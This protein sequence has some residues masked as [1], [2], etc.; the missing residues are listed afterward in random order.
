VKYWEIDNETWHMGAEAYAAA[1]NR[2]GPAMR[3]ADPSIELAACGSGGYNQDWN[4]TIINR[5]GG[6]FDYISTHHYEGP[7]NYA[8]GP[9][10]D[11]A[12]YRELKA[13]IDAGPNPNIKVYCSEWN[14]QS[15]DWRTGLYCG[16]IL[17]VFERCGDFF[18]IGGP[19]LFLRHVSATAWDNA[20]VNF[21][22]RTW[23]PAP[24]YV[25]MKLWRDHYCP[26]RI[27]LEGETG[28]LNVVATRSEDGGTICIKAVNPTED[29]M[30]VKA[31]VAGGTIADASMQLVAPGRLDARNTLD[32]RGTVRPEEAKVA[33]KGS[34]V[35]FEM[36]AYSAGAVTIATH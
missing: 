17:N 33:V 27:D 21:D 12:F 24:N 22:H 10:R 20:F 14:A 8:T 29:P 13:I 2:F 3:K 18:E 26:Q 19:A 15:T 32:S 28:G 30:S 4:R 5:S 16:G 23:F 31:D 25:V 9:A 35:A 6:S 7:E 36:P 11:E 34:T 1:V